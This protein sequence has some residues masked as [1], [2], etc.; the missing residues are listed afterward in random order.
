MKVLVACDWDGCFTTAPVMGRVRTKD[1][2]TVFAPHGWIC[3]TGPGMPPDG[4][5]FC[6]RDHAAYYLSESNS[7]DG[8]EV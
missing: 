6:S 3:T 8:E 2:T 1:A 4:A 7:Q 5:A